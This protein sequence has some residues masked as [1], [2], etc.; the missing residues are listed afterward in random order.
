MRWVRRLAAIVAGTLFAIAA[1]EIALRVAAAVNAR[2][3]LE[4]VRHERS[5]DRPIV[6][7]VGDS[8]IYGVYVE[9]DETLPR[10][11][12][13]VSRVDGARG[14]HAENRGVP[15]TPTWIAVRQIED[16]LAL[17]PVAVVA[18]AGVN[19]Y[20]TIPP[21][22]GLGPFEKLRVVDL[23]RRSLFNLR[24]SR[25]APQDVNLGTGGATIHGGTVVLAS[26]SQAVQIP[27]RDGAVAAFESV[28][29]LRPPS[30]DAFR[31]RLRADFLRMAAVARDGGTRL[32][33]ST[34]LAG[35]QPYF[36]PITDVMRELQGKE[37][38][39]VA[40]TANAYAVAAKAWKADATA[41]EKV[42]LDSVVLTRDGHPTPLGYRLEAIEVARALRAVGALDRDPSTSL[43]EVLRGVEA[44]VPILRR[45]AGEGLAFEVSAKA[46]DRVILLLGTAGESFWRA[47][48]LP[49]Q[50]IP[51]ESPAP[52]A[53]TADAQGL[54]RFA[55]P[56][57]V[58][59]KLG[60]GAFA[61]CIVERGEGWGS[62]SW[63]R[64]APL[65]CE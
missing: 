39:E 21:G 30:P 20:S 63:L 14:I 19:N 44:T 48:P 51:G 53:Q 18:T 33:L 5:G 57:D 38:I 1:A 8:N 59:S 12:E 13:K 42:A 29:T 49:I 46:G 4:H 32:V 56:S 36:S 37:G 25:G 27:P 28:G 15:G 31:T 23:V 11:V 2:S 3:A 16:V 10:A 43:G 54:A 7:F 34:Y 61:V 17:R 60:A 9:A 62:S 41:E 58:A 50:H 52:Q 55:V 45:I 47:L 22:E 6:A 40:D 64:S 65:A 35:A 26:N 24:V